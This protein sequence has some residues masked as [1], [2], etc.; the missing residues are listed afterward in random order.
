MQKNWSV[1]LR[2][3][4]SAL[5]TKHIGSH[6]LPRKCSP[7][8]DPNAQKKN[9]VRGNFHHSLPLSLMKPSMQR[10]HPSLATSSFSSSKKVWDG[11]E[12][13][14]STSPFLL[15][16]LTRDPHLKSPLEKMCNGW[17][18][19]FSVVDGSTSDSSVK[20]SKAV[21]GKHK[22]KQR[23]EAKPILTIWTSRL[24]WQETWRC[25]RTGKW[26]AVFAASFGIHGSWPKSHTIPKAACEKLIKTLDYQIWWVN[27]GDLQSTAAKPVT[28][29]SSNFKNSFSFGSFNQLVKS[30]G[31]G[32]SAKFWLWRKIKILN[33]WEHADIMN[34]SKLLQT[35]R[36]T[37]KKKLQKKKLGTSDICRIMTQVG[38]HRH[39]QLHGSRWSWS[40]DPVAEKKTANDLWTQMKSESDWCRLTRE[41]TWT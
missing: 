22:T 38:D 24:L 40:R 3:P 16:K 31:G 5:M 25:H 9:W 18:I 23:N 27:L 35:T 34:H 4:A 28:C 33:C 14:K 39:Q 19:S 11:L 21:L 29:I 41:P 32:T 13:P 6:L 26:V 17:R 37:T 7:F 15:S 2:A 8:P 36:K 30:Q 20:A 12:W 1:F 10:A